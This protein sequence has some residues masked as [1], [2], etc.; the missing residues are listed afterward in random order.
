MLAQVSTTVTASPTTP[1]AVGLFKLTTMKVTTTKKNR[2][3]AETS[4]ESTI[5]FSTPTVQLVAGTI[6]VTYTSTFGSGNTP[7]KAG[8]IIISG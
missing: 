6:T 7:G 3:S 2:G 1:P 8:T 5:T 4:V